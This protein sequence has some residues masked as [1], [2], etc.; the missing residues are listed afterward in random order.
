MKSI[1]EHVDILIVV[2]E[3]YILLL[4]GLTELYSIKS[5]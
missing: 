5:N 3:Q 4:D 1:E 2:V